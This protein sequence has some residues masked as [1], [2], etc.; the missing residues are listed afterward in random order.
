[1]HRLSRSP[2]ATNPRPARTRLSQRT[3][4]AGFFVHL[5]FSSPRVLP[6]V[7]HFVLPDV[8][9][10]S[11][12]QN[13]LPVSPADWLRYPQG[14]VPSLSSYSG[15]HGKAILGEDPDV[16]SGDEHEIDRAGTGP[17]GRKKVRLL[18]LMYART[19]RKPKRRK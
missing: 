9:S 16:M 8:T 10:G 14:T 2:K 7:D 11:S 13:S 1:M 3:S 15:W 17:A 12:E 5:Y 19:T 18:P 6:R 4:R